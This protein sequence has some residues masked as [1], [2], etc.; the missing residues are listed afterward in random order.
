MELADVHARLASSFIL[1]MVI[2]AVWNLVA[3][4]RRRGVSGTAFGILAVGEL[5]ALAQGAVG[6]AL[7]AASE[8][9][10]RGVHYLYGVTAVLT[11]PAC[12]SLT[13]GRDDSRASL[14]YGLLCLFLAVAG[15]RAVLTGA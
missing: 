4:A 12:Y 8:Q 2:A 9:P 5:L 3:A 14:I 15:Y 1:F 10:A 7:L 11:L 13:K 6:L